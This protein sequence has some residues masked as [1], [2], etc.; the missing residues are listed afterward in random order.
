MK[1]DKLTEFNNDSGSRCW[2]KHQ[3]KMIQDEWK[4]SNWHGWCFNII[5]VNISEKCLVKFCSVVPDSMFY[6]RAEV[7]QGDSVTVLPFFGKIINIIH[8]YNGFVLLLSPFIRPKWDRGDLLLFCELNEQCD[9]I[10]FAAATKTIENPAPA[11]S[12]KIYRFV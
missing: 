10:I 6:S 8:L 3:L 12:D 7:W 9:L 2:F 11:N 4:E 5:I 1:F